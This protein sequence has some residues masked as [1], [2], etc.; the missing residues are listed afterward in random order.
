MD[1][2][3]QELTD[4][5][6]VVVESDDQPLRESIKEAI[7]AFGGKASHF[8]V[9]ASIPEANAPEAFAIPVFYY[10]QFMQENGFAER[11]DAMLEDSDFIGD[12]AVRDERLSQLREDMMLAPVNQDLQDALQAKIEA[13]FAGLNMRFRSSTN[14]EDLDGFTGAGLYTSRTGRAGEWSDV[15]DA[16]REVWSSVWYFRAFEERSYRSIDHKNVGMALL[17]HHSFPNE[18]ANGVALTANLFDPSGLEPGF[19]VNVQFGGVSV[20]QPPE[21][22]TTDQFV[23]HYS[24]P[25]QPIV[26]LSHSNLVPEGQSVLSVQQT[27]ELGQALDAIHRRFSAAYG[28]A[29]GNSGWYAMDTEFK[30]DDDF[31]DDGELHLSVKQARPHPGRGQ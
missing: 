19:Y 28:P 31:D 9:L 12:P 1:T 2:S 25:G 18:E 13:E 4:I 7:P 14:A 15:L 16:I 10:D 11:V 5:R 29:A 3:K 27:H 21:G 30:F 20:V 17:V 8:S 23:Y 6:D 26:F 24:M 22:V